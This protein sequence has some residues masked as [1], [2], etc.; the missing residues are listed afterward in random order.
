[1]RDPHGS[2]DIGRAAVGSVPMCLRKWGGKRGFFD[3]LFQQSDEGGLWAAVRWDC[4]VES[5]HILGCQ[6]GHPVLPKSPGFVSN[7][8]KC[9]TE[10]YPPSEPI[11]RAGFVCV[12]RTIYQICKSGW[13]IFLVS[14]QPGHHG[15]GG[16]AEAQLL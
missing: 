14:G 10:V 2:N 16:A 8:R 4:A 7:A 9:L 3:R 13:L 5:T 15:P 6:P 11:L 1:M 12:C